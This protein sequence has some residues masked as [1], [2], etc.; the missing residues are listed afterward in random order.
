[1][2]AIFS[3]PRRTR[4][5]G[6]WPKI[7]VAQSSIDKLQKLRCALHRELS[8]LLPKSLPWCSR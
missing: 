3:I 8:G 5:F 6:S 4:I 7:V 1:M 2:Q